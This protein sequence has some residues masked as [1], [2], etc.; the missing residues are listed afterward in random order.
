MPLYDHKTSLRQTEQ[1]AVSDLSLCSIARV[2]DRRVV[3]D[4]W[5]SVKLS[6]RG[7][8]IDEGGLV[9]CPSN[10]HFQHP[11]SFPLSFLHLIIIGTIFGC[12]VGASGSNLSLFKRSS[13]DASSGYRL[14]DLCLLGSKLM[15]G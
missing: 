9:K 4:G 1:I 13:R 12:V 8:A 7:I 6:S 10:A 15:S 11:K 5:K 14:G 2:R 3:V